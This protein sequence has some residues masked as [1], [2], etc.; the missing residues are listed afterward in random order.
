MSVNVPMECCGFMDC[1][2]FWNVEVGVYFG[3]DITH[4]L[5]FTAEGQLILF[6]TGLSMMQ[7]VLT[8]IRCVL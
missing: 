4:Y 2:V 8:H 1:C 3:T 5:T 7:N 6:T